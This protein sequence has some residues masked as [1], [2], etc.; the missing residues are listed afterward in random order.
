MSRGINEQLLED[1]KEVVEI[2][3]ID[4]RWRLT[5]IEKPDPNKYSLIMVYSLDHSYYIEIWSYNSF[6]K[7]WYWV[8]DPYHEGFEMIP[9]P[10]WKP[11]DMPIETEIRQYYRNSGV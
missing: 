1:M 6:K 3:K 10:Y 4:N 5:E 7:K 8:E 2:S 9:V 11:C